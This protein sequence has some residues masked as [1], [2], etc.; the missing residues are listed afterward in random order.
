MPE[1]RLKLN[2]RHG[3][4]ITSCINWEVLSIQKEEIR[5]ADLDESCDTAS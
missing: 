1:Q 5:K 4:C 2:Q 3:K